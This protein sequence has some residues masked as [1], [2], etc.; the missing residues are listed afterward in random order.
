M[1]EEVS[2]E[3]DA[4]V[5]T[6]PAQIAADGVAFETCAPLA[7]GQVLTAPGGKRWRVESAKQAA[8]GV[9]TWA[10]LAPDDEAVSE[11]LAPV[12]FDPP[13]IAEPLPEAEDIP[14]EPPAAAKRKKRHDQ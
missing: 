13:I 10:R 11:P 7:V 6:G 3:T 9:Y 2:F 12:T 14:Q 1:W 8:G 5:V 4:G